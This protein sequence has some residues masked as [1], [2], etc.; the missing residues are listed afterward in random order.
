M[1]ADPASIITAIVVMSVK[2]TQDI[3]VYQVVQDVAVVTLIT[4]IL[5]L[6]PTEVDISE[7]PVPDVLQ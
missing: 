3:R 1:V 2:A 7:M 4:A 6:H 5:V